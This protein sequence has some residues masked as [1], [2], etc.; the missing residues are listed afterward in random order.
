MGSKLSKN[1]EALVLD[2]ASRMRAGVKK[3]RQEPK[4]SR[5]R[6]ITSRCED[7]SSEDSQS[8]NSKESRIA[9]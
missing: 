3:R 5:M 1:F 2:R 4:S 7:T 9:T 6:V 8:I